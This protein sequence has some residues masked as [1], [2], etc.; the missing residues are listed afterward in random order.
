MNWNVSIAVI[1]PGRGECRVAHGGVCISQFDGD[2]GVQRVEVGIPR[3]IISGIDDDIG[4][5]MR[6]AK[7]HKGRVKIGADW[8][9][10]GRR[11]IVVLGGAVVENGGR[12]VLPACFVGLLSLKTTRQSQLK[13][14]W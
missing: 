3:D 7:R 8:E 11:Y 5:I 2:S 12:A 4:S 1:N 13:P 6:E 9:I 10:S 14:C